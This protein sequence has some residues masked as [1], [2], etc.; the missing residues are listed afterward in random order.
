MDHFLTIGEET[1]IHFDDVVI[2]YRAGD[3]SVQL[4]F[5][6]EAAAPRSLSFVTPPQAGK[7]AVRLASAKANGEDLSVGDLEGIIRDG[8][9]PLAA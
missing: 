1:D 5:L 6:N 8:E 4:S 7:A 3:T 9:Q 2:G